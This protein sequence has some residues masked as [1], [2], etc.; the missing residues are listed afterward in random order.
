MKRAVCLE[1]S[2]S[3]TT[4]SKSAGGQNLI[5][6]VDR[7]QNFIKET[8]FHEYANL[9]CAETKILKDNNWLISLLNNSLGHNIFGSNSLRNDYLKPD[10]FD[11]TRNGFLSQRLPLLLS[12]NC[13]VRLNGSEYFAL[14]RTR[15]LTENLEPGAETGLGDTHTWM[16]KLAVKDK[17]GAKEIDNICSRVFSQNQIYQKNRTDLGEYSN[18]VGKFGEMT[19]MLRGYIRNADSLFEE[20]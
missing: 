17:K 19:R 15:V 13:I 8:E 1:C 16:V 18:V 12:K 3:L 5:N 10:A 4:K 2:K 9:S 7:I 14:N 20:N 11:D 6:K